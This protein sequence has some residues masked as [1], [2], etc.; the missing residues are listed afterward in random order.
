[1]AFYKQ[2]RFADT[3]TV[4]ETATKYKFL[5]QLYG[6]YSYEELKKIGRNTIFINKET[7]I[8]YPKDLCFVA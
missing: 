5:S 7:M 6:E 1:M 3:R 8:T 2:K 4:Q